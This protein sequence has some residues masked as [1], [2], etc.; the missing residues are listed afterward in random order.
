M[1]AMTFE[2]LVNDERFVS[3]LLTKTMGQL[4]LERPKTV[5]R[6]QCNGSVEVTAK[7]LKDADLTATFAETATMISN[8]AVPFLE[9]EDEDATAVLPDFAIVAPRSGGGKAEGSW[10]IMGD[11]KDY[12]RVRARIDDPRMLKGFLQVALGAESAAAWTQL[13]TG[14]RIHRCGALAVPRNA[15]LQPEA[16]VEQ[17][18]DHRTEVR[19]R[20]EERLQEKRRLGEDRP[21]EDDLSDYV[22]HIAATFDPGACVSCSL[23]SY[24]R[25][26]LRDSNQ[27]RDVLIEIGVPPR[28]RA[29]VAGLVEGG[30]AAA[31]APATIANQ[32][33]ATVSGKVVWQER[34]RTDPIGLPGAIY[35]AVAKSDAAAL[36]IY[37]LAVRRGGDSWQQRSF[38]EPQA[39]TARR[40]AMQMVGGEIAAA[41]DEGS[42]PIHLVVPDGATADLLVSVADSVA[43]VE[44]SRMRW[45]RDLDADRPALTF[46]GTPATLAEPLSS[47]ERLAVSFLLEE[48]RSR[49][50]KTRTPVVDMREALA[51]HVTPG[52]PAVDAFRLDYLVEWAAASEPLAHREV[53]DQIADLGH[54]PGARLTNAESDE[55]HA[56][57]RQRKEE[58]KAY[59]ELVVAAL[60]YK[61]TVIDR[62]EAVLDSLPVSKLRDAFEAIES[63]W[64]LVW[65]RRVALEALDLVRFDRTKEFWRNAQVPL[66]A[67]DETC[68]T[69]LAAI[70]D[71]AYA[72]DRSL[73]AG[74]SELAVATVLSADPPRLRIDSRHF[75][76]GVRAV[77]LHLNG[78]PLIE[79]ESVTC[80][81]QKT[82]F[83]FEQLAIGNLA[84]D[85]GEGLVWTPDLSP[86]LASGD[87]LI[88]ADGSWFNSLLANGHALT[89]VRPPAD[90]LAA[91][92]EDC[93]ATSYAADP[94]GH[95]W[96]CRPHAVSEAETADY[97]A[98]QRA[99]GKMNPEVWPPLVD[100]ERFDVGDEA[101]LD[102]DFGSPAES[103]T[104]DDLD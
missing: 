51:A 3:E 52:G 99:A 69:Q 86:Q 9:L 7:A 94:E 83:R 78:K 66:L 72:H 27:P 76:E 100:E 68:A 6:A 61:Q 103:L 5:A 37:G 88:V 65:G 62:A 38:L 53:S 64:Q 2:R 40:A 24:C 96:C 25:T 71:Y 42:F 82:S 58:P 8:L 1:R 75:T 23:F 101:E 26:E 13:P 14:M 29:G 43:G 85:G 20:V 55:I 77:A 97:F 95:R 31:Q 41:R 47:E 60:D 70:A 10:L 48:D 89:V 81:V 44:L 98:E 54:T 11:A 15:F 84:D 56:A 36:G 46:D 92:K 74:T 79:D 73:D 91:P 45:Q 28:Y 90:Q 21:T 57:Y 22:A 16:V 18:D 50:L 67:K 32:V 34:R 102:A 59:R 80:K 63:E 104:I 12:E 33:A 87:Q 4:G 35:V 19:D 17:L 39:P 30:V 49:A 93:T